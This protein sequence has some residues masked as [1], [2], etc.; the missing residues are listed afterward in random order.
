MSVNLISTGSLDAFLSGFICSIKCE[1]PPTIKFANNN[2]L[3][4]KSVQQ[5][6]NS[7]EYIAKAMVEKY[8]MHRMKT[9]LLSDDKAPYFEKIRYGSYMEGWIK[10]RINSGGAVYIFNKEKV[11]E[12]V[13]EDIETIRDFL[14]QSG[15]S[16]VD[17]RIEWFNKTQKKDKEIK[18]NLDSLKTVNEYADFKSLLKA[19]K[20]GDAYKKKQEEKAKQEEKYLQYSLKGTEL[21]QSFDNGMSIVC[22][23]TDGAK[24]FESREMHHCA[25]NG[26]YDDNEDNRDDIILYSLRDV[27]GKPHVTIEVRNGQVCQC[28]GKNNTK[29]KEK[30]LSYIREF[31]KHSGFEISGDIKYLGI[32]K[33]DGQYYDLYNLPKG[34]VYNGTLDLSCLGLE[35]LPDLSGVEVTGSFICREN[36][37][38][39]LEGAP[40]KV[41]GSFYCN[42]NRLKDLRGAPKIVNGDFYCTYNHLQSIE[43]ASKYIGG[44]FVCLGNSIET[45]KGGPEVVKGNFDCSYNKLQ[46]LNYLPQEIG[47]QIICHHNL[48]IV[49][50][51]Q[52]YNLNNLP[53]GFIIKGDL[54][55]SGMG[56]TRLPNLSEV[57][58]EGDFNCSDNKLETLKGMPKEVGGNFDFSKNKIKEIIT[59]PETKGKIIYNGNPLVKNVIER[60]RAI[61]RDLVLQKIVEEKRIGLP[62]NRLID[63]LLVDKF[64]RG[65][66]NQNIIHVRGITRFK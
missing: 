26:E 1:N 15:L 38:E 43:G 14:Y 3:K 61:Y 52:V 25:G 12:E 51:G 33:Q 2:V 62:N 29:P 36:S 49:Q 20:N 30:Y 58:V 8:F 40:Y 5:V 64:E 17:K 24:D 59:L 7:R 13:R 57:V 66:L 42:S 6:E 48:F 55:L 10:K 18:I 65:N 35:K 27:K 47:G 46:N 23:K 54:D 34:F 16:Y 53:S 39:S 21:V 4:T 19:A 28:K 31:V 11:S 41:G 63:K 44:H 9:F 22:L 37:L 60:K 56:L 45:L 32:F 50:D